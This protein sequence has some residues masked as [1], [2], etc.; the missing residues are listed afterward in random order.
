MATVERLK[1]DVSSV[2]P[3]SERNQGI[4]G[5]TSGVVELRYWWERGNVKNKNKLV[6]WKVFV[7]TMGIKCVDLKYEFLF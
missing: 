5:C 4:V 7:D 1:A 6:E 3:S 2:T